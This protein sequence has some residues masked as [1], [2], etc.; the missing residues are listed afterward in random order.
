MKK[1]PFCGAENSND[2][3]S[4]MNCEKTPSDVNKDISAKDSKYPALRGIASACKIFS[5][6]AFIATIIGLGGGVWFIVQKNFLF[7]I[8]ILLVALLNGIVVAMILEFIGEVISLFIDV[9]ANTR[10]SAER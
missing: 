2:A 6:I 10:K 5:I 7:G 4:C 8:G 1:C 9:E 3:M